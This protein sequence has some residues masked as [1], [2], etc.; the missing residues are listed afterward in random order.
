MSLESKTSRGKTSNQSL[1]GTRLRS[2]LP[3]FVLVAIVLGALFVLGY[4]PRAS[5]TRQLASDALITQNSLPSATV[6]LVRQAPGEV[7]LSLPGN[8]QAITE[9]PIFA[10]SDGYI[11]RRLAD[12]GDRVQAG[13]LLAEIDSPE[14][15]Q[16]VREAQAALKRSQSTLRQ[17]EAALIQSGANL[18]LAEV[19]AKRWQALVNEGVLSRQDGD[20]KLA[21]LEARKA[22]VAA[23]EANV[24]AA[25]DAISASEASLQRLLELQAFRQVRAPFAGVVTARN[26]DVGTLVSAGS[27]SSLREMFRVA[28]V[29]TLRVLVTVPQ[30][31]ALGVHPG[32][33]CRIE[34]AEYRGRRFPGHVTRTA[35]SLDVV[36]RTLLTEIQIPNP[37]GALLPGMYATVRLVLQRTEPPL[38]IPSSAFRNTDNGPVV[39]ILPE[40]KIVHFVPVKLGRDY[41]PQIEV[42]WGLRAGQMVITS[43]TDEIREGLKVQPVAPAKPAARDGGLGK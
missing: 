12:I 41:G 1:G 28:Q 22:D 3:I 31:E 20:E 39:A 4:W 2:A 15:G 21:A 11:V 16:Q 5:R 14:L 6:V 19:T 7:E 37:D 32:L 9:A 30:S 18:H 40:D 13:Q 23:A 10:R 25:R 33:A 29:H 43:L 26:V 42:L 38:L 36:S 35:M 8:I 24:Q 27:S 34:V 17:V